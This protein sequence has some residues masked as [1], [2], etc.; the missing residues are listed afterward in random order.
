MACI[1]SGDI[2]TSRIGWPAPWLRAARPATST[3]NATVTPSRCIVDSDPLDDHRR[4][5]LLSCRRGVGVEIARQPWSHCRFSSVRTLVDANQPY[6]GL[7]RSDG[8]SA[9]TLFRYCRSCMASAAAASCRATSTARCSGRLPRLTAG[10]ADSPGLLTQ[11]TH[12]GLDAGPGTDPG[13]SASTLVVGVM[14]SL[15]D[16]SLDRADGAR[17]RFSSSAADA[18]AGRLIAP[19]SSWVFVGG[20]PC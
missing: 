6:A 7:P 11:R 5:S 19:S 10:F 14:M 1:C 18:I 9:S 13:V 3:L 16:V 4:H 17:V 8:W 12:L 20:L 15:D 2:E